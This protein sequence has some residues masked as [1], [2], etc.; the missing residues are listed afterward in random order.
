[1]LCCSTLSLQRDEI[2]Q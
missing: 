1:M 2:K